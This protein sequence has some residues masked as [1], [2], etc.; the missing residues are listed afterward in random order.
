MSEATCG[1]FGSII[2]VSFRFFGPLATDAGRRIVVCASDY[3]R[4]RR[5]KRA[6]M[7][8]SRHD[9]WQAGDS[10]DHY[11]G[12]WSRQI[13]PR[14]LDW[15]DAPDGLGLARGRL[16]NRCV[17]RHYRGALQPEEPDLDRPVRRIHHNGPGECARSACHFQVGDAQT[18]AMGTAS[19]DMIVSALVLN[20]IP[21]KDKA[22]AE[23]KRVARSG[24]TVG[25]HVWDYPG[26]GVEFIRPSG[27]RNGPRSQRSRPQRGQ[28]FSLLN[29]HGL[30]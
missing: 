23:M 14:F 18:L 15:L 8:T 24:A 10:Y 21:D 19:K 3:R 12:R 25:F 9:G 6:M 27:S 30:D 5:E 4:R 7:Q 2:P 20:F 1:I 29:A 22:L 26:G 13:A 16:W 17:V 11:M 28:A